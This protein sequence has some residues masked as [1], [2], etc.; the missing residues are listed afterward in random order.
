[1]VFLLDANVLIDANRD[2]YSLVC[3][4]EFWE[5]LAY[6]GKLGN[7][8]IPGEIYD[9]LARGTDDLS[10]WIKREDIK[11][12]LLLNEEV[13]IL[14]VRRVVDEGYANDLTDTEVDGLGIDPFLIAYALS[15]SDDEKFCVVSTENS[16]PKRTRANRHIPDVCDSFG[17]SHFNSYEFFRLLKFRTNWKEFIE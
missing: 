13:D 8:K 9:E 5:W 12:C 2:Y 10:E 7:V 17:I 3:V 4:P 16:K 11:D 1:M 15:S 6:Q 14:S